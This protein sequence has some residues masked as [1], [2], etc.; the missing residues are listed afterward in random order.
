MGRA[1]ESVGN[2]VTISADAITG[3]RRGTR[4]KPAFILTG[5]LMLGMMLLGLVVFM[6]VMTGVMGMVQANLLDALTYV[7]T[8]YEYHPDTGERMTALP[9][10][11]PEDAR[12]VQA[13]LDERELREEELRQIISMDVSNHERVDEI[14]AEISDLNSKLHGM[15]WFDADGTIITLYKYFAFPATAILVMMMVFSAAGHFMERG[16]AL[17][18][19]GTSSNILRGAVIGVI[20]I[21]L[22]PEVWD[23][24]AIGMTEASLDIMGM[25]GDEPQE[26]IDGMWCLMGSSL[27]C[28]FDFSTLLNPLVWATA[29]TD[30]ADF[31]QTIMGEALLPFFMMVPVLTITLTMY[32]VGE[33]RILFISII[34]ITLPL[35]LVM[36]HV[37][38]LQQHSK[39]VIDN[40]IGA[41]IAPMLTALTLLVGWEYVTNTELL[42]LEMWISVLGIVALAG[43]WPAMLAPMIGKVSGEVSGHMKTAVLSS[44]MMMSQM[45]T[46]LAT[47]AAAAAAQG[48]GMGNMLKGAGLGAGSAMIG[49]MPTQA[50]NAQQQF[51]Q[52]GKLYGM[53]AQE[54]DGSG[55]SGGGGAGGG[56][57]VG[58]AVGSAGAGPAVP[59]GGAVPGAGG[60]QGADYGGRAADSGVSGGGLGGAMPSNFD[61]GVSAGAVGSIGLGGGGGG[62]SGAGVNPSRY[63]GVG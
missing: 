38:Y 28:L 12:Q 46:G 11:S 57:G 34:L 22:I 50:P 44:T 23:I 1:A 35:W 21:W 63:S 6:G 54:G 39:S 53:G 45:G 14:N 48:G 37:P 24:F 18:K 62:S 29:L 40:M 42:A 10:Y 19:Q 58:P 8:M 36:R 25:L 4:P 41:S 9:D 5:P 49:A 59:A 2:A 60:A 55:G 32:V 61:S 3:R 27:P 17:W 15:G 47:G 56:F 43:L 7:P 31:G 13:W 52:A 51:G 16:F 30:P 26:I 33:V 20:A